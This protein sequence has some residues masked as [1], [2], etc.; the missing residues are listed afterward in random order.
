MIT[1]DYSKMKWQVQMDI[2]KDARTFFP[3]LADIFKEHIKAIERINISANIFMRYVVLV[4]HQ[5]SPFLDI[6]DIAARKRKV[7][8]LLEQDTQDNILLKPFTADIAYAVL[9]FLKFEYNSKYKKK[10]FYEELLAKNQIDLMENTMKKTD[11][12]SIEKLESMISKLSGETNAG[13]EE[14]DNFAE[15]FTVMEKRKIFPEEQ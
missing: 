12:D 14:L 4:Y 15:A 1:M 9:Q 10:V 6:D 3:D 2:G 5:Y 8:A 13:D 11:L 7:L